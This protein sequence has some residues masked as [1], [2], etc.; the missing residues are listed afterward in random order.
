MSSSSEEETSVTESSPEKKLIPP[1]KT[2][3]KEVSSS[4]DNSLDSELD[5]ASEIDSSSESYSEEEL[6]VVKWK[7]KKAK[8]DESKKKDK[9]VKHE[10]GHVKH[11]REKLDSDGQEPGQSK[12]QCIEDKSASE[13]KE[14]SDPVTIVGASAVMDFASISTGKR[15]TMAAA[16]FK[17]LMDFV[18]YIK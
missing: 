12:C 15:I 14:D 7:K 17:S 9:K 4:S 8:S 13:V 18:R 3:K 16:D 5:N 10:K 1:V 6:K 11:K 2:R